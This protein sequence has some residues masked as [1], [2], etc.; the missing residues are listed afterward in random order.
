MSL[1]PDKMARRPCCP[2]VA[3]SRRLPDGRS[4]KRQLNRSVRR[5]HCRLLSAAHVGC[6]L[7]VSAGRSAHE[8]RQLQGLLLL[9]PLGRLVGYAGAPACRANEGTRRPRGDARAAVNAGVSSIDDP[10]ALAPQIGQCA[11]L[12]W[13]PAEEKRGACYFTIVKLSDFG[14]ERAPAELVALMT[15]V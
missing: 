7:G 2:T 10:S 14:A 8:G 3:C 4:T 13:I 15:S 6:R 5:R 12:C 1:R 11:G 9:V